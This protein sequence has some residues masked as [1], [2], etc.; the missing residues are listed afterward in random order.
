VDRHLIIKNGVIL[1]ASPDKLG[2][3]SAK[4]GEK[5]WV[6]PKKYIG[7][8]WFEWKDVFVSNGLVW[9]WGSELDKVQHSSRWPRYMKGYNLHSGQMVNKISMDSIFTTGH[10]HRCYRNKATERYVIA[11]RR[12]AEFID[13]KTGELDVNNWIRGICH[14]GMLPPNGLFYTPPH[15]CVCYLHEKLKGFNALSASQS[16]NYSSNDTTRDNKLTKGTAF[17]KASGARASSK[18]WPTYRHDLQRSGS[19]PIHMKNKLKLRWDEI[20]GGKLSPPVVVGDQLF[21]SIID[22]YRVVSFNAK[23]GEKLWEYVT[24]G[25]VDTPP[26]YYQVKIIFGSADGKVYCLRAKDGKLVW[27]FQAAPHQH[28]IMDRNRLESSWPLHGS[29]LIQ[30]GIAYFAAGRSTHLDGGIC[31]YALDPATGKL[32]HYKHLEGPEW[33]DENYMSNIDPP[34]GALMDILQGEGQNVY[35]RHLKFDSSLNREV[36]GWKKRFRAERGRGAHLRALGGFLD[37]NYFKRAYWYFGQNGNWARLIVNN[38]DTF[39]AVRMFETLRAL[40]TEVFFTPSKKGYQLYKKTLGEENPKWNSYMPVR[41]KAMTLTGNRLFVAGPPDVIDKE[42]PLA[43][44][45]G[46]KGGIFPVVSCDSGKQIG[47]NK[48]D[49]PPVFNGMAAARNKLYIALQNSKLMCFNVE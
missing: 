27:K 36:A 2:G 21:I 46:R 37:D 8:L 31:L 25:R 14:Y 39:Y 32:L 34:Q 16:I 4:T 11:S 6:K 20:I 9:T 47:S 26:T 17:G 5:L 13:L 3:L 42:D 12:G 19:V 24:G 29:V 49:A 41:V 45:E 18:D 7:W 38:V 1:H 44:F 15:P 22:Q 35:M 33:N 48:L 43:A 10:H 40:D 30:N 28:Y 23:N